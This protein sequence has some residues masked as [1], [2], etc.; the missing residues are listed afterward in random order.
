MIFGNVKNSSNAEKIYPEPIRKVI[1]YLKYTDFESME[2][3]NYEIEGKDI[4]A[5]VIDLVTK[6][7]H[8]AKPEVHRKYVDVQ[9]L[10]Y[11]EE[12]IGFAIDTG[13]NKV[14]QE[15][16]SERDIIFYEDMENEMNLI[17]KPGSFAV[18][19]PEDVHRPGCTYQ[20]EG[21]I[22][23]VVVKVNTAIL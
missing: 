17:M 13:K 8:A 19:F 4:Y 16:L 21:A 7:K 11:G 20:K 10:V 5:Q 6:G 22:R 14:A 18:F 9:F 23:K 3:G 2:P 12:L 1:N 15:L